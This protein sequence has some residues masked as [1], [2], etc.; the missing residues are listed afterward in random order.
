M[1]LGLLVVN[2]IVVRSFST[3]AD[4]EL[5]TLFQ[6]IKN[7]F[8]QKTLADD[9]IISHVRRMY[10]RIG[11]EPT[12]YRP[13][14]EAMMRRIL[15]NKG[16][17][18]INNIVDLGNICSIQYHLP[19]GLYDLN[20]IKD[21]VQI[22]VGQ[23]DEIYQGISKEIIHAKGKLIL[24]DDDG[25]F[26]NPTADSLRTSINNKTKNVLA[27]FFIPPEIK[28]DYIEDTLNF[29]AILYSQDCVTSRYQKSILST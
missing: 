16:L 7:K 23:A 15:K 6:Y 11:W 4:R 19:L 14:S 5:E 9:P 27:V 24:R 8:E 22:D 17:Y 21:N 26:G 29:L 2:S 20:K 25:I 10:R 18:R 1:Q 3:V 13:S 12:R 28:Q